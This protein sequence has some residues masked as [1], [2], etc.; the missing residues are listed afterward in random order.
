MLQI[1]TRPLRRLQ[2][3]LHEN[4]RLKYKLIISYSI[5]ILLP[6]LFIGIVSQY[7]SQNYMVEAEKESLRQSMEQLNNTINFFLETYMNKSEMIFANQPLQKLLTAPNKDIV[8]VINHQ[9]QINQIMNGLISDVRYPYM[10]KAYY[11]GGTLK[12]E[13]YVQND[14]LTSFG[15]EVRPF[16]SVKDELW[17]R[18]LF[19]SNK[20]F[21]WQSNVR[22]AQG[23][24]YLVMNRRLVDFQTS[25]N[26]GILRLFIPAER[27]GNIIRNNI[28]NRAISFSYLDE[29]NTEILSIGDSFQSDPDYLDTIQALGLHEGINDIR[30]HGNQMIVGYVNSPLTQWKLVYLVPLGDVTVK[31]RTITSITIGT[32]IVSLLLCILLATRLSGF[33][34]RR[35]D[36]LVDKT[37]QIGEDS[38]IIRQVL[39]GNDEIS[40]LDKN[41]NRMV[42]RINK[43]IQNEYASKLQV[44]KAKLELYQEQINPHLLYNTLSTISLLARKRDQADIARITGHLSQFYRSALSQGSM[45]ASLRQ[46]IDMVHNY[47]EIMEFVYGLEIEQVIEVDETIL[48]CFIIKLLLQP[49]VENSILHGL[50]PKGG[51]TITLIGQSVP[52]GIRLEISDDG[53]GMAEEQVTAFLSLPNGTQPK[54]GYGLSNVLR[55]LYLF[56][57]DTVQ[58]QVD[59]LRD[60]G[61]T[62]VLVIPRLTEAE[63]KRRIS[64]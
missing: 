24:H 43:L 56:F 64:E 54:K 30:L 2:R 60:A 19:E 47:M 44:N 18:S 6:T 36:I 49:I 48:D 33:I 34:T 51:G 1:I 62:I 55:R 16:S 27:V 26:I 5:L 23:T 63:I 15:G 4:I 20:M 14:S 9:N 46:E 38:L 12:A 37:N 61:T 22:D 40:Q 28:S 53:I 39:T 11:F 21:T 29:N 25:K 32:M 13:L 58:V 31:T 59:S 41:F 57:G 8:D 10:Q 35:I 3:F 42:E 50:R 52:E 45:I 7:I 17:S